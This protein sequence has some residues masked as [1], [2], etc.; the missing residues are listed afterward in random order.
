MSN[1]STN[2]V[3]GGGPL[4]GLRVV[5]CS[6][7]TA[8]PRASGILSDYGAEVVWVE[9]IG[10]DPWREALEVE[11][12]VYNRGKRSVALDW[13]VPEER[14]RLQALIDQAD[15]FIHN[16]G[17]DL[18]Y[19][20]GLDYE[21]LHS[22]CPSLIYCEITGFGVSSR[23]S[24]VPGYESLVHA[25]LGT[26]AD[27]VGHREGP[28][29]EGLPFAAMG[30]A[31]LALIG[32]L[33]ALYRRFEDGHGR[34]VETSL[35][36]GALVYM[37]GWGVRDRPIFDFDPRAGGI[38]RSIVRNVECSDSTYISVHTGAVGAFGRLLKVLGLDDR[39]VPRPDG[40]DLTVFATEEERQVLNEVVPEVFRT[41]SRDVW[42]KEL[43][44]ADV[45]VMPALAPAEVFDEPQ[46]KHNRMVIQVDDPILGLVE[47]VG[48]GIMFGGQ[49]APLPSRAPSS[50]E[51]NDM[52]EWS[53]TP[54]PWAAARQL[55]E[56]DERPL[57]EGVKILDLG[58]YYAGPFSSRLLA[59]LGADV[60][61]LEPLA[62]DPLRGNDNVFN[63]GQ[64]NKRAIAA[65][66]KTPG[67]QSI[68]RRLLE[69][70]DIVHHNMRP[71]SAERLGVSYE[72]VTSINP[73]SIYVYAPGWG[74][75]GP[76]KDR[77]SFAPLLS[78]YVG[79][80]MEVGGRYNPPLFPVGNEDTGNG[81]L[82]AI[83]MLMAL[84]ERRL[85]GK[86]QFIVNPQLNAALQHVAHIV[87]RPS[88]EVLGAGKLDP[89]QYG[90]SA[91]DRIYQ[92]RDGWVCLAAKS[93]SQVA[94]LLA[95]V[96]QG[97]GDGETNQRPD[98]ADDDDYRIGEAI[99]GFMEDLTTGEVVL[100]LQSVGVPVAPVSASNNERFMRDQENIRM[101]RIAV[102]PDPNVVNIRE[103][104]V[105]IRISDC[106]IPEHR[107][108]PLLG[109]HTQEIVREL[110]FSEDEIREL[111]RSGAIKAS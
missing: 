6:R 11:Y 83:A 62:G 107:V 106:L 52:D 78:V 27:Q 111:E 57:L 25:I 73:K 85:T 82:G 90:I 45:A 65:N 104:D 70:A 10:G 46:T 105:L 53:G 34:K 89:M 39:I 101:R 15:V 109:E 91:F 59:D 69:Q 17:S 22:Q 79:A 1:S 4:A 54:S 75:D 5:D 8:G 88:G 37:M 18:S 30:A 84:L 61:K 20:W 51:H 103:I 43:L 55:A 16:M 60:V 63:S 48:P 108:A 102:I 72:H 98:P 2:G 110:G 19:K 36:D 86:G 64:A 56:V 3:A 23:Y 97:D 31:S 26:M 74:A 76:Y 93:P 92:T 67:G 100:A 21:T 49:P 47:Q 81:L 42:L 77:Q 68:A 80:G 87:R 71:G 35:L 38:R 99:S 94:S 13:N 41:K 28:I 50:G 32:V 33:S 29:Y 12:A 96:G 95:L 66:L 44:E 24:H 7:G 14:S 9:P 40:L 58:A